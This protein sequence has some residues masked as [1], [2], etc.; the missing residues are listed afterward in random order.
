MVTDRAL[1]RATLIVLLSSAFL[2]V[3]CKQGIGDRCVQN[4]DCSS[5]LCST[6]DTPQGGTCLP[7]G[8]VPPTQDAGGPTPDAAGSDGAVP[9]AAAVGD[10]SVPT[11]GGHPADGGHPS[12]A[13]TGG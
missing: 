4:S 1:M 7:T 9:D 13:A 2:A 3:G 10:S 8:G 5:G 12:D 11:D 6:S